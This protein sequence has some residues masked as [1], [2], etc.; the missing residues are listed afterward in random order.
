LEC[1]ANLS[2]RDEL[3]T[4]HAAIESKQLPASFDELFS[5][6]WDDEA[7]RFHVQETYIL[8]YKEKIPER[9]T[10]GYGAGIVRLALAFHNS[11]GGIIVFGV[12]D[13]ALTIEGVTKPFDVESFNRMLTDFGGVNIECISKL[14]TIKLE[15]GEK[16]IVGLLVPRRGV[17][18]PARLT[19]QLTTYT[20]R[21]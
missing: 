12:K 7:K 1:G 9:F 13:R 19:K 17:T 11:F 6:L 21:R 10:D 8:D 20:N 16:T 18:Q 4:I 15:T 14:Y 2:I 3:K 5:P